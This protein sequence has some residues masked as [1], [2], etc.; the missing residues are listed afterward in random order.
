MSGNY[1]DLVAWQRAMDLVLAVYRRTAEVPSDER[2]GLVSQMRRAAVSIPSNIAEGQGRHARREYR[3]FLYQARGSLLEVETQIIIAAKLEYVCRE[4]AI[5][6]FKLARRTA[7]PL[8]GLIHHLD[9]LL[10]PDPRPPESARTLRTRLCAAVHRLRNTTASQ[11]HRRGARDL[12]RTSPSAKSRNNA[13]IC[14]I[15]PYNLST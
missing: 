10:S 13:V 2:F 12:L 6:L 11:N 9:T 8:N 7:K 3:H 14:R 15:D 4:N 1:R 5:D